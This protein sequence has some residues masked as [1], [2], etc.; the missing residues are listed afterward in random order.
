M[1]LATPSADNKSSV[2]DRLP[3]LNSWAFVDPFFFPD[4]IVSV[5]ILVCWNQNWS[6]EY[7]FFSLILKRWRHSGSYSSWY[8]SSGNLVCT[9]R[10]L[11]AHT[12]HCKRFRH[13][14]TALR[15]C[16][17]I[18][19]IDIFLPQVFTSIHGRRSVSDVR[20]WRPILPVNHTVACHCYWLSSAF[21]LKD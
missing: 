18:V 9:W 21:Y 14:F 3:H 10:N 12:T 13:G 11:E 5:W 8:I 16:V 6:L 19:S 20:G 17:E 1:L 15:T 2:L 4:A 7:F